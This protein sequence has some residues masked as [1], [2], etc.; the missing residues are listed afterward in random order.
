MKKYKVSITKTFTI[1]VLA[2]DT[3]IAEELA[4]ME[5]QYL[6]EK[7]MQHYNQTGD[8]EFECFDVTDIDDDFNPIN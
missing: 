8:T 1:D 7:D 4:E 6:E 5:L 2:D 3:K